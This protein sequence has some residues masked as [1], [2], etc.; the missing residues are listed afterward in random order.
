MSTAVEG[1]KM[2]KWL[3]Y[4]RSLWRVGRTKTRPETSHFHNEKTEGDGP[5]SI[6]WTD[7]KRHHM[8]SAANTHIHY[9]ILV[10]SPSIYYTA[11]SFSLT[12]SRYSIPV[13]IKFYLSPAFLHFLSVR[14][15]MKRRHSWNMTS[16]LWTPRH[17]K[18]SRTQVL[19]R[20]KQLMG[21]LLLMF[22]CTNIDCYFRWRTKILQ[23]TSK[24][25]HQYITKNKN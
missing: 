19:Q 3:M 20:C 6:W 16:E 22:Y 12:T 18:T 14:M 13:K 9:W 10:I 5:G 7:W 4:C 11:F 24:G 21:V 17:K 25:R 15:C 23:Y 2:T 1:V 8:S